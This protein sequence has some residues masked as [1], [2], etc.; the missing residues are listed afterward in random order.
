MQEKICYDLFFRCQDR[1][2]EQD[3]RSFF[4]GQYAMMRWLT[5]VD[6][7]LER[8]QRCPPS[9]ETLVCFETRSPS[10]CCSRRPPLTWP[11]PGETARPASCQSVSTGTGRRSCWRQ[12]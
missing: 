2:L 1:Y 7:V 9:K 12:R 6:H 3:R 5:I 8:R 11:T 4:G 10:N